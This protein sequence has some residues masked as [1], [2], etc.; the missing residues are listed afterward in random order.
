[1]S[2][3]FSAG[4]QLVFGRTG[5]ATAPE[6]DSRVAIIE[7]MSLDQLPDEE[8]VA[9]ARTAAEAG[10]REQCINELFRRN[11]SKVARWCLRF[12]SD[13][14]S[15]ADLAQEI[16]A[17]VYQ[18]LH[19]F[20]GQSKFSTWLFSIV[21]NHSLNA[22][23]AK[24]RQAT[25]LRADVEEDFLF[26]IPD[27][28]ANPHTAAE[29]QASAKYV[30]DLLNQALDQTEK[31]IFTLHYAEDVPLETITRLLGLDNRSGAKAYIVSAKRKLA[32]L[33]QERKMQD[34]RAGSR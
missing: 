16:F 15:A 29:Q 6:A 23:R 5:A 33:L 24:T 2:C 7:P 3:A 22:V 12:T 21:R 9:R 26:T 11:Y 19:A 30:S 34:Q 25:E 28:K 32:R 14:E 27:T 20:Q 10:E 31:T 13:R 4:Y 17:K 8:L 18:N 1:M